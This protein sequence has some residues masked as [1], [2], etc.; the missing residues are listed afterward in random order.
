M[1]MKDELVLS[2][3]EKVM[4]RV[5]L[6]FVLSMMECKLQRFIQ[7]THQLVF[8]PRTFYE[9][10]GPSPGRTVPKMIVVAI[11]Y[12][13]K[14]FKPNQ[15]LVRAAREQLSSTPLFTKNITFIPLCFCLAKIISADWWWR[16]VDNAFLVAYLPWILIYK[17]S[18]WIL[19]PK[20]IFLS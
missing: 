15:V 10:E 16:L 14:W 3:A 11:W 8:G 7:R 12:L 4:L 13:L 20:R 5:R 2:F 1:I 19:A 9:W 17:I 18:H 6:L